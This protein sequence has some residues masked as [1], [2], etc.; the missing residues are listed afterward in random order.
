MFMKFIH[1]GVCIRTLFLHFLSNY[2]IIEI[3]HNVFIHSVAEGCLGCLLFC[4]II[5]KAT[6]NI[7][8]HV[9]L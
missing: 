7:L 2:L 1:V 9:F 8:V 5:N 4:A 6:L 3:C